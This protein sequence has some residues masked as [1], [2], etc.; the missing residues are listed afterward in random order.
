MAMRQARQHRAASQA[1]VMEWQMHP[2]ISAKRGG[3]E[4]AEKSAG[5]VSA[6]IVDPLISTLRYPQRSQRL[7]VSIR[8]W[9]SQHEPLRR[10]VLAGA[11]QAHMG[12]AEFC[13]AL[14]QAFENDVRL[15]AVR[16]QMAQH[17]APEFRV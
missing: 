16:T 1:M 8:P 6:A 9:A 14:P 10:L 5:F 17:H 3:A 4:F 13:K 12:V 11:M 15:V 7:R 2:M